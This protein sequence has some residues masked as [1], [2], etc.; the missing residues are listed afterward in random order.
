[1]HLKCNMQD[2]LTSQKRQAN[3]NKFC[4]VMS[5]EASFEFRNRV[6]IFLGTICFTDE[7]FNYRAKSTN[8]LLI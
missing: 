5:E 2:Y 4:Y 1:M 7:M 6:H 8:S 3:M